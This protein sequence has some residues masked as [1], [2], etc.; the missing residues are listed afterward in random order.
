VETL[1]SETHEWLLALFVDEHL[2]LLAVDTVARGDISNCPI[3][4]SRILVRAHSLRADGFILVHNHPS[5]DPQPSAADIR[6]TQKVA[7]ISR[8]LDVPL[9][10]H[11]VVAGEE[12]KSVG[13]W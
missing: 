10:D 12:I 13:F 8:E 4:L 6:I 3:S 9:R 7:Y 5:G 11:L 1:G 2:Q